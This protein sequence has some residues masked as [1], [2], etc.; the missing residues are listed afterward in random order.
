MTCVLNPPG[1]VEVY[2]ESR[3]FKRSNVMVVCF[4]Y[5][6]KMSLSQVPFVVL[7]SRARAAR[8]FL[9]CLVVLRS[10]FASLPRALRPQVL[11]SWT[12]YYLSELGFR[13]SACGQ[14]QAFSWN[15][16][17]FSSTEHH[18]PLCV[19]VWI[20]KLGV[21]PLFVCH[22]IIDATCSSEMQN[23]L[24]VKQLTTIHALPL[25][26]GSSIHDLYTPLP[27]N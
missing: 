8:Y 1:C 24:H 5:S 4:H 26:R 21:R 20:V 17:F 10:V 23:N 18:V 11:K 7:R 3:T 9:D 16:Q 6:R 2:F 25:F 12:F 19:L 15:S 14:A 13:T 22:L 27:L